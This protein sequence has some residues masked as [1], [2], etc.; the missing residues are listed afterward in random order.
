MPVAAMPLLLI[1]RVGRP[2][3]SS[4]VPFLNKEESTCVNG[5]QIFRRMSA[6]EKGEHQKAFYCVINKQHVVTG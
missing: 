2:K 5:F 3:S 1:A 4:V 6:L